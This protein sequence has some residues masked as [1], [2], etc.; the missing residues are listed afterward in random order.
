VPSFLVTKNMSP[1]LAARVMTS[2]N[3]R[4]PG[5]GARRLQ[6]LVALL[7]LAG[8]L[9]IGAIIALVLYVRGE[10]TKQLEHR[11]TALLDAASKQAS[12]LT[13]SD[14]E[15]SGRV[16][17]ALASQSAPAYAGDFFADALRTRG[18]L[19]EALAQPMLYV[20]GPLDA[21]G[22]PTRLAQTAAGSWPDALALCLLD[23]PAAR[24][25]KALKA[26]ARAVLARGKSSERIAHVERLDTLLRVLPLLQPAWQERVRAADGPNLSSYE[27]LFDV[28]PIAQ[29]VR[30]AKAR[31][32][33][34]VM[35]EPG[36]EKL[37]AEL[38]GERA[39]PIRV[40]LTDLATGAP[41]FRFRQKVDPSWL[42]AS[43]RAE[44]ASG[45]DSCSLALD[46]RAA[47]TGE[48]LPPAG[49]RLD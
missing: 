26:K 43:A 12:K 31:Q 33:L 29:A 3:G 19:D 45:I 5:R 35:D 24:S 28:A 34:A 2:V 27:K 20:R 8:V 37:P 41:L 48:A 46:L 47:A 22:T 6:P 14:L 16:A 13:R 15:L 40:T 10:R 4:G 30:A 1:E 32:L 25:E 21:L 23:P 18:G 11:R 17:E 36:D 49:P 7:R 38:D 9:A 44:Y 42:S 39:H